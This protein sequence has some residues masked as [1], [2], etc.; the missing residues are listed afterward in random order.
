MT[1]SRTAKTGTKKRS[2]CSRDRWAGKTSDS[3][4]SNK[5]DPPRV[6]ANSS[7]SS[8]SKRSRS[9]RRIWNQLTAETRT[10]RNIKTRLTW[11]ARELAE[12]ATAKPATP[13]TRKASKLIRPFF[14]LLRSMVAL[15]QF[16]FFEQHH[17]ESQDGA[18]ITHHIAE[19]L[20]N[21]SPMERCFVRFQCVREPKKLPVWS[22]G[23][24]HGPPPGA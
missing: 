10:P 21:I 13:T 24:K 23:V 6:F 20:A 22:D 16:S 1:R 4:P 19:G 11:P 7:S 15:S 8:F 9:S 5:V 12:R 18:H 14:C 2:N 3:L 17:R